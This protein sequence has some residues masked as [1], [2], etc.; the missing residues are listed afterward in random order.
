MVAERLIALQSAAL[1]IAALH[2]L[3]TLLRAVVERA[4]QLVGA[5]RCDLYQCDPER[6]E[7]A[8]ATSTHDLGDEAAQAIRYGEGIVGAVAQ[9][10]EPRLTGT[11]LTVPMMWQERVCAVLQA[12]RDAESQPFTADDRELLALFA[13]HAAVAIENARL[14][15]Q[16][17]ESE[18]EARDVIERATD[19]ITI[20]QDGVVRY[21]NARLVEMWGGTVDEVLGTLFTSYIH[22]DDLPAVADR[23]R[24]R[25]AG[26]PVPSVFEARLM[27]KDGSAAYAELNAGLI[28]YQGRPADLVIVRDIT[29]RQRVA[30]EMRRINLDLQRRNQEL[31]TLLA[32]T[33]ALNQSLETEPILKQ[34]AQGA[35]ELADADSCAIYELA[36]DGRT[37]TVSV[38]Y[39]M[40]PWFLNMIHEAHVEVG[41][42]A[43][44][45]AVA[46]RVAV[47]FSD[48]LASPEYEYVP[49]MVTGGYRSVLA[50]P[51][52]RGDEVLGGICLWW[53]EPHSSPP[54]QVALLTA[55]AHQAALAIGNARAYQQMRRQ[56]GERAALLEISRDISSSLDLETVL[57]RIA[58]YAQALFEADDSEVYL[59]DADGQTLRAIAALGKY[60][61]AMKSASMRRGEGIVGHVAQSGIAEVVENTARDARAKQVP[62]TPAI[63][64][65]TLMC[66]P[67]ISKGEVFG[68]MAVG[69]SCARGIFTPADLDFLVGLAQHAAVAI[70]NARLYVA[71]QQHAALLAEALEKQRELDRL[72]G[73]FI[74]NVSHELRMPLAIILGYSELLASGELGKLPEEPHRLVSSIARRARGLRSLTDDLTA[75]LEAER[76]QMGREP[77]DLTSLAKA[78][79]A[80]FQATAAEAGLS[81]VADLPS[82]ALH[83]AGDARHL[84]R[85]LD[86]LL[87]NAC[88][89]TP[90]GGSVVLRLRQEGAEAVLEVADTGI[91]IA[92]EHREHLFE[93]FYQVDGSMSRRHGGTGLGLALVREI[94]EAHGGSVSVETEPGK[95]ST[96]A[97][98]LPLTAS[99][100]TA[101]AEA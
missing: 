96:F 2:D 101:T 18:T 72:K 10:G 12:V 65:E 68:V 92:P 46:R 78:A 55:L 67:L 40:R 39:N 63:E 35:A 16:A 80:D 26:E 50:V 57:R 7:M 25:L 70:E 90:A 13:R 22:P 82:V 42:G 62:G 38:G 19:G 95:G 60:A 76:R 9:T 53:P 30:E 54:D 79:F 56:A 98:R 31:M 43:I 33:S 84:P 58:E 21:A 77:V 44:G 99:P 52:I 88:K 91:G 36:A 69:R 61:A 86:N 87:S 32:T 75:I 20:I 45:R 97:V 5:T 15:Q 28:T 51:M 64:E 100:E 47:E 66:A 83:V 29:E 8:L 85:V 81:L 27:R 23:Y 17:Q 41:R 94:V 89:F 71:E 14:Y 34:I 11:G 3:P 37:L 4:A 49:V 24:R 59:L 73:E 93:R 6:Q 74:Q 1:D 48:V